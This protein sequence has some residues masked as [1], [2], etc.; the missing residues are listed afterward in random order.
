[1][2]ARLD[3]TDWSAWD[4]FTFTTIRPTPPVATINDHSLA[5]N[6][7]SQVAS[8]ISYSDADGNPAT[9]YQFWDSGTAALFLDPEQRPLGC[10]YGQHRCSLRPGVLR[11]KND[12]GEYP[13]IGGIRAQATKVLCICTFRTERKAKL[14]CLQSLR[15]ARFDVH[16]GGRNGPLQP[17]SLAVG[18]SIRGAESGPMAK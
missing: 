10:K 5:A 12:D 16:A 6:Q 8:W 9:Q 15:G 18:L 7:W 11:P 13:P 14:R 2:G 3:G 1:V 4:S 17:F